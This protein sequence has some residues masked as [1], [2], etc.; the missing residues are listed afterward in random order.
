MGL[1]ETVERYT[2]HVYSGLDVVFEEC[3]GS[4]TKHVYAGMMHVAENRSGTVEYFYPDH[5]GSTRLKTNATGGVIYDTNY[6]PFGPDQDESDS[7]EFKY[8]GKQ[9]DPTELY[10][11]GARYYDPETGKF[12]TEDP[13][14]GKLSDPQS[15]NR[16]VVYEFNPQ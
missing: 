6:V 15:Q 1:W 8:T 5:L 13:V 9:E 12:I 16:Y 10:Y 2:V 7:E 14:K 4:A 3:N 11:Y